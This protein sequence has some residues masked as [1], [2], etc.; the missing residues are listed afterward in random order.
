[1][2]CGDE[3]RDGDRDG[4]HCWQSQAWVRQLLPPAGGAACWGLL[5]MSLP[6]PTGLSFPMPRRVRE[7]GG[8]AR[9]AESETKEEL[10]ENGEEPRNP[11][12]QHRQIRQEPQAPWKHQAPP[13]R[14]CL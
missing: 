3:T 7:E 13:E 11:F 14:L 12:P 1:M 10:K 6:G 5:C 4:L 9:G 2:G 8:E